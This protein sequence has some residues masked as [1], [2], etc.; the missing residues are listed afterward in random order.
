M[1]LLSHCGL[2]PLVPRT[3]VQDRGHCSSPLAAATSN[4]GVDA[5]GGST[6][7][8][9]RRRD[10]PNEERFGLP[11]SHHGSLTRNR[12]RD[13]SPD[14]VWGDRLILELAWHA[15]V[16]PRR[17]SEEPSAHRGGFG[18]LHRRH[19]HSTAG[20]QLASILRLDSARATKRSEGPRLIAVGS[21]WTAVH[22]DEKHD[23]VPASSRIWL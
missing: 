3:R 12:A 21:P 10:G 23:R 8:V 18:E 15:P 2:A 16:P 14:G 17:R 19:R 22:R 5:S 13:L 11:C 6:N 1:G 7:T 20:C 4:R 9:R